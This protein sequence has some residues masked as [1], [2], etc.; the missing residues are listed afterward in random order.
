MSMN[1]P[2][3]ATVSLATTIASAIAVSA[4][5][6][7]AETVLTTAANTYAVG[8]FLEYVCG[9]SKASGNI[10][11]VKAATSTSVTL[12]ALDTTST[13]LFPA[14]GGAGTLRKITTWTQITQILGF[15]TDGGDIQTGKY[16]FLESDGE[17][18]Y[19]TVNSAISISLDI[20]DDPTL[21]G[22][23]ALRTY[24][25]SQALSA[26]RMTLKSGN[27]ILY[28]V[29]AALNENPII[30]INEPNKVQAKLFVQNGVVRY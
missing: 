12:E 30:T 13:A 8:D 3:G 11:R 25:K 10:Y 6:N 28:G 5:T 1:L 24:T 9:W 14:G 23:L 26:F 2:N 4:A 7:A 19:A 18:A 27:E 17:T 20:G 15:T 21:A 22:Y 16:Q 29:K